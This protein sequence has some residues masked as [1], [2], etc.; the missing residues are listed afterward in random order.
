M[1]FT[2][3]FMLRTAFT[4]ARAGFASGFAAGRVCFGA[5][6]AAG[7]VLYRALT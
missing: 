5:G 1:I 3:V 7:F 4:A 2:P 6:F